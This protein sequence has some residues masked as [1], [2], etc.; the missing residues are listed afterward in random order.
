MIAQKP[1]TFIKLSALGWVFKNTD[2]K[3]IKKYISEAIKFFGIERC[4]FGSNFPPDS[5]FYNFN[6]LINQFKQIVSDY[7]ASDQYKLFYA[8]AERIYQLR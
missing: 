5:L 7:P 3:T 8:N 1:N 2:L 6:D 4:M